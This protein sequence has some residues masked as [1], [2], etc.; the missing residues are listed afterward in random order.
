MY[1]ISLCIIYKY[2]R[3]HCTLNAKIAWLQR[4]PI[5]RAN[6][7]S[8]CS[9]NYWIVRSNVLVSSKDWLHS[10]PQNLCL[11][12]RKNTLC[13][14]SRHLCPHAERSY[15]QLSL[16]LDCLLW[17]IGYFSKGYRLCYLFLNGY[18]RGLVVIGTTV[19]IKKLISHFTLR[20][21]NL[22]CLSYIN[23]LGHFWVS[24]HT[25]LTVFGLVYPVLLLD[26]QC[27]AKQFISGYFGYC[28]LLRYF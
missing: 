6:N 9:K 2:S 22:A 25:C 19:H 18:T 12:W 11:K 15:K 13:N 14:S 21:D 20:F 24:K 4:Q 16:G 27:L 5:I 26:L 1:L 17:T 8:I 28:G 7:N 23:K 10:L 3:L